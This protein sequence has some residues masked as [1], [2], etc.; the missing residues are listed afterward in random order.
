MA[1]ARSEDDPVLRW[2]SGP[3]IVSDDIAYLSE[4]VREN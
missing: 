2:A 3:V 4:Q 1:A